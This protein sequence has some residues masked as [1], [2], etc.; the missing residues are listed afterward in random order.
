M[1]KRLWPGAGGLRVEWRAVAGCFPRFQEAVGKPGAG[2]IQRCFRSGKLV[3]P[4]FS[5]GTC[6]LE[7]QVL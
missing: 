6:Q 7:G 3:C 1:R 4:C 5:Q 2:P